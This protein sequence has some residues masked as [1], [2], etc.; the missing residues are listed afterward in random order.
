MREVLNTPI[1]YMVIFYILSC[2]VFYSWDYISSCVAQEGNCAIYLLP[3]DSFVVVFPHSGAEHK[4]NWK[5]QNWS[6]H[7]ENTIATKH[8]TEIHNKEMKKNMK[9]QE[10]TI[11]HD[12]LYTKDKNAEP[13][14]ITKQSSKCILIGQTKHC[15]NCEGES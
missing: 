4:T 15:K 7:W 6:E 3:I 10:E 14:A 2:N 1:N 8:T 5:L 13:D 9:V 12:C 11:S